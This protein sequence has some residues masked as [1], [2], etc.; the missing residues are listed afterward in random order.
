MLDRSKSGKGLTAS[1]PIANNVLRPGGLRL[2][3]KV[4]NELWGAVNAVSAGLFPSQQVK[5]SHQPAQTTCKASVSEGPIPDDLPESIPASLRERL[6]AKPGLKPTQVV[7]CLLLPAVVCAGLYAALKP[8]SLSLIVAGSMAALYA[9]LVAAL[10]AAFLEQRYQACQVPEAELADADSCF[11]SVNGVTVHYKAANYASAQAHSGAIPAIATYHGFGAN[12]FS[13]SFVDR[14]L[15]RQLQA[16][17]VS[18]DMPGFGLTQR[19]PDVED[20]SIQSNGR[21]G[22]MVLDAELAANSFIAAPRPQQAKA[23]ASGEAYAVAADARSSGQVSSGRVRRILVGHSLGAACAA[24]EVID[25]PEGIA[26]LVLVAPAIVAPMFR[27]SGS[28][29]PTKNSSPPEVELD[30]TVRPSQQEL[31]GRWGWLGGAKVLAAEGAALVARCAIL[32]GQPLLVLGLR[33]AVRSRAFWERGL[34]SAWYAKD[35]VTPKIVDAYRLPQLV[36]GW[37][38][39]LLRFLR[40]RV[41]GGKNVWK[42]LQSGYAQATRGQAERLAHAVAQHN[43]KVLIIHGEQDA[44][45]PLWNSRRLAGVLPGAS[46][47]VFTCCGHMPMEECPDRFIETV[48]EFV[49]SM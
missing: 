26:A 4:P 45:V 33:S 47:Q 16:L 20:Y 6:D 18:H 9:W 48:S 34:A 35:G 24:A 3:W 39:G 11:R 22:R 23:E 13:W 43:I 15:A 19:T 7:F 38:W 44:L 29:S 40:A 37:E 1:I 5:H 25:H 49:T 10:R 2:T 41:A 30:E 17:V 14:K 46:L 32:L 36:R 8:A 31:R 12:T 27:R 28:S 21:I 42:A